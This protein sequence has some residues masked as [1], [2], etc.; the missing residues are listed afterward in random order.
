MVEP[1]ELG[2]GDE[3]WHDFM[4]PT[5][6]AHHDRVALAAS[7]Q[8]K[9]AELPE[10]KDTF[11]VTKLLDDYDGGVHISPKLVELTGAWPVPDHLESSAYNR[12]VNPNG[13]SA[14]YYTEVTAR[15]E[16]GALMVREE[17]YTEQFGEV[18]QGEHDHADDCP[19]DYRLRARADIA[20]KRREVLVRVCHLGHSVRS[21]QGRLGLARDS[22]GQEAEDLGVTITDLREEGRARIGRTAARLLLTHSP[23]EI[24][25][26]YDCHAQKIRRHVA[27]HTA[28]DA[29]ELYEYRR[30]T[31]DDR[32]SR[33]RATDD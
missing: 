32:L 23:A 3:P 29:S 17:D 18:T 13:A 22:L 25:A 1:P 9:V 4:V 6:D 27:E 28:V 12:Y 8:Q 5:D 10:Y 31:K 14:R 15:C 26:A 11:R 19:K 2:L 24:G 7:L 21:A 30:M 16:C 20:K 33:I